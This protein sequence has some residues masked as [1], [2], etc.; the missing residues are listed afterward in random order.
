[1]F[2]ENPFRLSALGCLRPAQGV[3]V[4]EKK[5]NKHCFFNGSLH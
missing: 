4:S 5:A 3:L 2:P 1:M